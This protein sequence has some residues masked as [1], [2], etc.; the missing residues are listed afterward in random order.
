MDTGALAELFENSTKRQHEVLGLIASGFTTKEIASQLSISERT[1][2]Q[3]VD[4]IRTKA[5]DLPRKQ[6]A[7]SYRSWCE[8]RDFLTRD[9]FTIDRPPKNDDQVSQR[10]SESTGELSDSLIFDQRFPWELR[11]ARKLSEIRPSELGRVG[12]LL[13]MLAGAVLILMIAILGLGFS[14][15]LETLLE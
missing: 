14:E 7:R 10:S 2:N 1:V 5:N 11:S 12:I 3:H 9:S 6:I 15:G 13:A 4:A 8:T